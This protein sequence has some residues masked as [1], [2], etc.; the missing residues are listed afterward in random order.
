MKY[1]V[2]VLVGLSVAGCASYERFIDTLNARQVTSCVQADLAVGGVLP[3]GGGSGAVHVYTA[4]G[5]AN[6]QDCIRVLRYGQA[7]ESPMP[8]MVPGP[9]VLP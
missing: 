1:V 3:A 4:T 2:C 5:G 7:P 9:G 6:L 8:A